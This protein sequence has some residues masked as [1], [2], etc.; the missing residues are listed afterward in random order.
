MTQVSTDIDPAAEKEATHGIVNCE[1]AIERLGGSRSLFANIVGRFLDDSAGSYSTLQQAIT[2]DEPQKIKR[3]AHSLKGL[4]A[5][6]GAESVHE[7]LA[8]LEA[9]S[10][11]ERHEDGVTALFSRVESE[12]CEARKALQAFREGAA[13]TAS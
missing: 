13:G 12:M 10:G 5:M 8:N 1:K 7:A 2:G 9:A 11:S 4:A 3:A 6:C